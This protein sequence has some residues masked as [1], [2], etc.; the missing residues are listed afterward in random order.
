MSDKVLMERRGHVLAIGI[1]RPD[2]YNAFDHDVWHGLGRA[3]AML[4]D[5]PELRCGLVYATG[6]HFTAGLDLPQWTDT[7][8]SGEWPEVPEGERDPVGLRAEHRCS[9]P[10]VMAIHGICYTIGIELSLAGDV[11]ICGKGARFGQIEPRRGIMA[12]AGATVRMV[13]E[14]GYANAQRYLLT[15]DDFNA[16]T[17]LRIGLVQE[18]VEDDE[19]FA[20][21]LEL[22]ERIAAQAPLAVQASLA[23]SRAYLRE[24]FDAEAAR[25]VRRVAPLMSSDDAAEGVAS[26][27]ERRAAKFTG[28]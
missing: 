1:N 24:G 23:S 19:V 4:D 17:A 15:G 10:L 27:V 18:V 21:G 22:A 2:K 5:D 28:R 12:C 8:A 9:K 3:Y 16:E 6:K 20:K 11:R 13:Q 7:F 25:L 26:F 14:F